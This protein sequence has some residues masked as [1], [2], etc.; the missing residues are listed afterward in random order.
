MNDFPGLICLYFLDVLFNFLDAI[1]M[2][3]L[4][5][6]EFIP[7]ES[8]LFIFV[9]FEEDFEGKGAYYRTRSFLTLF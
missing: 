8:A 4:H 1:A 5:I 9:E 7:V 6:L 2:F 3:R